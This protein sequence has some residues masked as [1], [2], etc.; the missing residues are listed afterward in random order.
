MSIKNISIE[1]TSEAFSA[2]SGIFLLN[3]LWK[4]LKLGKKFK[5]A[6][7]RKKRKMGLEQVNK[8]KALVFSF[9]VGKA[10]RSRA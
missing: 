3:D 10:I 1:A 4:S 2:Y 5:S 8:L 9:A 6:L 7:P